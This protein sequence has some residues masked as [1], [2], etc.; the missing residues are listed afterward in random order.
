MLPLNPWIWV[1]CGGQFCADVIFGVVRRPPC[2]PSCLNE[3]PILDASLGRVY[4]QDAEERTY[5]AVVRGF[6]RSLIFKAL[7]DIEFL[8]LEDVRS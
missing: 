5:L 8:D 1:P 7:D 4:S 6:E 2:H 3:A